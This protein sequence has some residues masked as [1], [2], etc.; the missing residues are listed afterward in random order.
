[1]KIKSMHLE[2]YR[3]FENFDIDFDDQLTVLVGVNGS[4]KTA[5]LDALAVF[6]Q[7]AIE[8]SAKAPIP[9]LM[10]SDARI[11]SDKI[12]VLCLEIFFGQNPQESQRVFVNLNTGLLLE[13]KYLDCT[14]KMPENRR[15]RLKEKGGCPGQKQI[16]FDKFPQKFSNRSKEGIEILNP[17]TP[18]FLS[19]Y[20]GA[21]RCLPTSQASAEQALTGRESAFKK[22]FDSKINF[23][24]TLNWFDAK[25]AEEARARSNNPDKK[26]YRNPV[27][28]AVRDAVALAL[29]DGDVY[30]FPHMDGVPPRL[31]VNHKTTGI[32]YEVNQLSD[33][34]RTMLA[35]VMDLARR[36]AVANE[37][38]KWPEGQSALHSPAIVLIDEVELHLHPS[39]QQTVLPSLMK[40]FPQTQFIVTT[41]S[42][43]VLTTAR[44]EH[45]RIL[46]DNHR[47]AIIPEDGTYGAESSRVLA[48]VF[49]VSPRPES[50]A[51]VSMLH[52]YWELVEKGQYDSSD[53]KELRAELEKDLGA[54][55][56]DLK[57]ADMR[58]LQLQ[59]LANKNANNQ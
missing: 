17:S 49:S 23:N 40:I 42:P 28:Q 21:G 2:N 44:K 51:S 50:A 43:Q 18:L 13:G 8:R 46:A 35:L 32:A 9:T 26:D 3:C 29:G 24:T 58:N 55:D 10:A 25:D 59:V 36:M 19:A 22:A 39:W 47:D 15:C 11:D 33:G 53:A 4:G 31:F 48:E 38:V 54:D 5:V 16:K 37:H 52:K 30:E 34:Y 27:L 6:L 41:H 56:P 7:I 57:M 20:Y 12:I 1:M 14:Q 45:I